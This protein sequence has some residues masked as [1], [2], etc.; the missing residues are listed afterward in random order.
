M[1]MEQSAVDADNYTDALFWA[2]A[3]IADR[4]AR[5]AGSLTDRALRRR[6]HGTGSL[7]IVLVPAAVH[8]SPCDHPRRGLLH[9]R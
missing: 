2:M 3:A 6:R 5:C 9:V 1:S 8:V 7:P 4:L